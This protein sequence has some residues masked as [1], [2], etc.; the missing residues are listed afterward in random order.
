MPKKPLPPFGVDSVL[1]PFLEHNPNWSNLGDRN[2]PNDSKMVA[3][4]PQPARESS[5]RTLATTL[6]YDYALLGLNAREA[7]VEVIRKAAKQTAARIQKASSED[8]QNLDSMLS[9]LATSTYR[10]LDPRRR[11]KQIERIQL[12]IFSEVDLDL[13]K[14]ARVP[15][16]PRSESLL[17]ADGA[18]SGQKDKDSDSLQSNRESPCIVRELVGRSSQAKCRLGAITLSAVC[19]LA[20]AVAVLAFALS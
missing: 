1:N 12:C 3:S 8:Q 15:L 20:A 4:S 5:Q 6:G 7:R 18:E 10:L 9:D 16:L 2:R 11:N 19:L 17:A 14:N 13:Q